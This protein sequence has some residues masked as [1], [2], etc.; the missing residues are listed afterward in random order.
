M[1]R[2]APYL[3]TKCTLGHRSKRRWKVRLRLGI[4]VIFLVVIQFDSCC[5]SSNNDFMHALFSCPVFGANERVSF[6]NSV[7]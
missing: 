2:L 5:H 4:N 6:S 3:G 7:F 1:K